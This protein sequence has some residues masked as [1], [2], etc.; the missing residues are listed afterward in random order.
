MTE[1]EMTE[2]A[3]QDSA[4]GARLLA[5]WNRLAAFPGGRRLFS[6]ALG[7]T[8]PYSG[9]IGARV[10]SLEPGRA[11][12]TLRDR[13][14]VRNHLRS[15]HAIALA[16]LG[17]LASGLAATAAMPRGV[18]GIP[19]KITIDYHHKA[20]GT[21]TATGIASFP[22]VTGPTRVEVKAWIVD[23]AKTRVATVTVEWAVE[24]VSA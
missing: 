11:V 19:V 22:E 23:E 6:V 4:V 9:S 12:L 20:R 21:L 13:K 8:A 24:R 18:R 14:H 15:V 17:E 10:E 7:R 16:N 1:P 2:S 5:M 3:R